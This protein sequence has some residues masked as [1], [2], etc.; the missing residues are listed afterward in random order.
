LSLQ[1]IYEQAEPYGIYDKFL[2]LQT[3]QTYEGGLLIGKIFDPISQE[4]QGSEGLDVKIKG[5][6]AILDL[7]GQQISISYVHNRLDIEDCIIL[8]GNIRYRGD[9][10]L[11][12]DQSPYGSVKYVTFYKPHDYAVRMQ[13]A[14]KNITVTRNIIVDTQNT[15]P[16]YLAYT[17]IANDFLPTGNCLAISVFNNWYGLP[18]LSEN[19]T[20]FSSEEVNADSLRHYVALCEY[21]CT[22]P[23]VVSWAAQQNVIGQD[24]QL[25]D[26]E[27]GDY[28][29]QVGSSAEDYGCQTFG[30][31]LFSQTSSKEPSV[32]HNRKISKIE[33]GGHITENTLWSADTVEVIAD[34]FIENGVELQIAAGCNIIFQDYYK[35]Y[36][37]G[38]IKAF[39]TAAE[40]IVFNS[41]NPEFF[42]LDNTTLGS[43]NG[44]HFWQTSSLNKKS[45][46]EYCHF[47]NCKALLTE[48]YPHSQSG[49]AISIY[50][51]SKLEIKNCI[52]SNNLAYFGGAIY[53]SQF[54][55]ISLINNLFYHNYAWEKGSAIFISNSYPVLNNNTITLN[56]DLNEDLNDDAAAVYNFISKPKLYNNIIY[57]NYSNYFEHIQIREP[58]AYY[59][60]FNNVENGVSGEGNINIEPNFTNPE[61]Y[62]F[63]LSSSSPCIDNGNQYLETIYTSYDLL[64]NNRIT[65]TNIDIGAVE[66]QN[67]SN[68]ADLEIYNNINLEQNYP[69]PFYCNQNRNYTVIKYKLPVKTESAELVIYN[70]LGQKVKTYSL[71][72][73]QNSL[74]WD[75]QD[76][77]G[78]SVAAGIYF[79]TLTT[80]NASQTRKLLLLK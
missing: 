33:V 47:R 62:D 51:F 32:S 70:L 44:L 39:G 40:P 45:V 28:R 22:E 3:G 14:G 59:T 46:L 68:Q 36:V 9:H 61:N 76:E 67:T 18:I 6:G 21:G 5:N 15:G 65:G 43:W 42:T 1:E 16:D 23:E 63:S 27:N 57:N 31:N 50:N 75:G 56:E 53:C 10:G 2:N 66:F 8:N 77:L 12:P 52:F 72:P 38:S 11:L 69:N 74:R 79:Y 60:K 20:Y 29:V 34:I 17:G 13:G 26:P 48:N 73:D 4:L 7:Q 41:A 49:G 30:G 58:K 35:L 24:P 71:S 54:S 80:S 25:M 78:N 55:N 37:A 64:G 19:W